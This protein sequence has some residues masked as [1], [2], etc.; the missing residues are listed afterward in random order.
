MAIDEEITK[1]VFRS[2][3]SS[4]ATGVSVITG[5][6]TDG[7]AKPIGIVCNSLASISLEEKLILWS[8]DKSS[9]SYSHWVSAKSFNVHFLA[10]DQ[11]D[12]VAR[13]AKKGVDKFEGLE[14]QRSNLGNPILTGASVRMECSTT[15]TFDTYDHM[16]IIGKVQ[17]LEN[18]GKPPLLFLHSSLQNISDLK[19]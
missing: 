3:M 7:S 14:F 9:S 6:A 19:N 15:Q 1:D 13:F 18:S 8:V 11:K 5:S 12:L 4:W 2:A 17:T 16:L 10:E